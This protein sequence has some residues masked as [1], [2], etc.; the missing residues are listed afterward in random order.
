MP[1]W[2]PFTFVALACPLGMGL[3]MWLMMRG[4]RGHHGE[5][6]RSREESLSPEERLARLEAERRT[7]EREIG[8]RRSEAVV[9]K[10]IVSAHKEKITH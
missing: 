6:M 3:M 10:P 2:L 9:P 5:S 8:R 4:M 1:S 7:L